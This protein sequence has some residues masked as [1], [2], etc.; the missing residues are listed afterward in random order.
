MKDIF[1]LPVFPAADVFPMMTDD[2]LQELAED[3]RANGL[4]QPVTIAKIN[5]VW[6]LIDGRNRREACKIAGVV[7]DSTR[8]APAV[9]SS[10]V[11]LSGC[12]RACSCSRSA[13]ALGIVGK[14]MA[15]KYS[16]ARAR[17]SP[18]GMWG[19]WRG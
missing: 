7:P 4:R 10:R 3:I 2:E 8:A 14:G 11:S 15:G 12:R 1:K 13:A 17:E 9:A 19:I 5:G 18:A 16:H 6:M